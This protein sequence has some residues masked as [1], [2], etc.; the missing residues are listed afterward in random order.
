MW[1]GGVPRLEPGASTY[2]RFATAGSTSGFPEASRYNATGAGIPD[3]AAQGE[4]VEIVID[5]RTSG[6]AGT[7]CSSPIF[8]GIVSL[9]NE[10]RIQA[11]KSTLGFL[12]P[13]L[14]KN[15]AAFNDVTQGSNPGAQI[16]KGFPAVAGW[17]AATGV[18]TPNFAALSKVV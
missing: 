10:Q 13:L 8:S 17:D 1:D 14:Y 4:N 11:G 7:S 18:G 16:G 15:A 12:N 3:V 9:R 6:V 5:G 2:T